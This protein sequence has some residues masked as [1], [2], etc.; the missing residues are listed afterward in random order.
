MTIPMGVEHDQ[1]RGDLIEELKLK[2]ERPALPVF[3]VR[4]HQAHQVKIGCGA[5]RLLRVG[6]NP[7]NDALYLQLV[8]RRARRE[9]GDV[10]ALGAK[11]GVGKLPAQEP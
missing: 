8:P 5:V 3:F 9:K 2:R 1:V 10:L 6:L 11:R 7:Q 4:H